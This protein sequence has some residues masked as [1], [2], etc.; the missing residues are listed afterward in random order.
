MIG[1]IRGQY[2]CYQVTILKYAYCYYQYAPKTDDHVRSLFAHGTLDIL[3]PFPL[4]KHFLLFG[5]L[6]E[7]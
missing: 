6:N 4:G 5:V 2:A 3:A 7:V 1:R